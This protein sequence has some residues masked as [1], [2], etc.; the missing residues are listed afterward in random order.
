[1]SEEL[2]SDEAT[3][4]WTF[5]AVTET[6]HAGDGPSIAPSSTRANDFDEATERDRAVACDARHGTPFDL[7]ELWFKLCSGAWRVA[8]TFSTRERL[9]A[10]LAAGDSS[11]VEGPA[12]RGVGMLEQIL[13]GQSAKVV[14][15]EARVSDSTVALAVKG[16]LRK[17]GLRCRARGTPHLIVMAA[18]AARSERCPRLLGRISSFGDSRAERWVVS[19][20]RPDFC[21]LDELSKAE[22]SVL[23][24][25]L[26]G[27]SHVQIA[28]LRR[29]SRRTIA[30]QVGTAFRKLGVSGHA[31]TLD[32]LMARAFSDERDR[33]RP[34]LAT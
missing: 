16:R 7:G 25:L 29:T 11:A 1:M 4:T 20:A 26:E 8:Y 9:Y 23:L 22:R 2:M 3:T 15:L 30:N 12:E 19:A 5:H 27:K 32:Y 13:L 21:G 18:R 33:F 17:M 6:A 31:Q 24:E 14:A 28:E 10:V 34:E